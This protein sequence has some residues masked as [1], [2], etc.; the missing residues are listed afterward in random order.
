MRYYEKVGLLRP[1]ERSPSGYRLYDE[2]AVE[3]LNFV[4]G[5]QQVGLRLREIAE[6]LEVMDRG[7]CPCGHTDALLRSRIA[8]LDQELAELTTLRAE[9]VRLVDEHP[10]GSC[11]E[12]ASEWWC[13]SEFADRR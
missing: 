10:A 8:D 9:L 4:R 12:S 2:A 11:R 6:L 3:R 7:Q 5:A 13:R 1:T